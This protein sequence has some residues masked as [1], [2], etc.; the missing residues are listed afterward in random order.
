MTINRKAQAD[1]FVA[2]LRRHLV[3][4]K[5]AGL[6]ERLARRVNVWAADPHELL[7]LRQFIENVINTCEPAT[8]VAV[9]KATAAAEISLDEPPETDAATAR[10]DMPSFI[11]RATRQKN[12]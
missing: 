2:S 6:R 3:G 12:P 8:Q 4:R 9:R 5:H 1:A 10:Q 7:T 11:N